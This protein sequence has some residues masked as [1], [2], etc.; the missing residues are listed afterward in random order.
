VAIIGAGPSG[1]VAARHLANSALVT[2]FEAKTEVGGM[3]NYTTTTEENHPNLERDT[4]Y[5]LYG[6]LHSSLY[7]G[8]VTNTPKHAMNFKDF[9]Q[10]V[11]TPAIMS[12]LDFFTYLQ[13]YATKFRL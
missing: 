6:A 7:A 3:W 12:S 10:K 13:S 2:V 8:L 4:M 11:E 1:L 5:K 9:W